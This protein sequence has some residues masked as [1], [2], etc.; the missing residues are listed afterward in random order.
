VDNFFDFIDK[1]KYGLLAALGVYVIIF[2]YLQMDS[3]KLVVPYEPFHEGARVD[4]PEDEI[5][6]LPENIMVPAGMTDE[7]KNISRDMNDERDR[8]NENWSQNKTVADV[9][10]EY[11]KLEQQMYEEAGGSKTREQIK[12][13]MEARKEAAIEA[14]K[15]NESTPN[16]PQSNGGDNAFGGSVLADF[17]LKNRTA[18]QNNLWHIRKPGYMC[19]HGS[20]GKVVVSVKVN[21]NGNVTSASVLQSSGANQCMIDNALKYAKL[22]RFNYSSSAPTIQTGK[23]IYQFVSQ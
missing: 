10:E 4:V 16:T 13:E 19:G 3:F 7:V 1:Y 23:I 6:L 22:S 20:R 15:Q 14:A 18:H 8:S 11:R 12:Q 5:D 17:E 2:I 21:Q 9:E